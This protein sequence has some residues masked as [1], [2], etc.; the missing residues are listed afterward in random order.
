MLSERQKEIIDK[1]IR[2]L[3]TKGIQGLTIKNLSHEIGISEPAIYRHFESKT[4]ILIEILRNFETMTQAI[5][6]ELAELDLPSLR[7][8][9][10]FFSRIIEIFIESPY[11]ISVIFSEEYFKGDEALK[12]HIIKIMNNN[13]KNVEKIIQEGQEKGELRNDIDSHSLTIILLGSI[14]LLIKMWDLQDQH[15]N[16]IVESRKM[17]EG[18][19]LILKK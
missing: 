18:L 19:N 4:D 11:S 12:E 5:S 10:M 17:F 8:L 16:L 2:I 1:S 13:E 9:E 6:Q 7:K 14:R 3:A 15:H